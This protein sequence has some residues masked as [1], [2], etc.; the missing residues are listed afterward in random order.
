MGRGTLDLEDMPRDEE[1]P[2][3]FFLVSEP[4]AYESVCPSVYTGHGQSAQSKAPETQVDQAWGGAR[5]SSGRWPILVGSSETAARLAL[6][7][8]AEG[9]RAQVQEGL[10]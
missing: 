4:T 9:L 10:D 8:A 5:A 2:S 7:G 3:V 1:I 6:G